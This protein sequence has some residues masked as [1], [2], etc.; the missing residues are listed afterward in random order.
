[1]PRSSL[2]VKR[3][4]S[5]SVQNNEVLNLFF[6]FIVVHSISKTCIS[7]ANKKWWLCL[8]PNWEAFAIWDSMT[9]IKCSKLGVEFPFPWNH[10]I[11]IHWRCLPVMYVNFWHL[12]VM[13]GSFFISLTRVLIHSLWQTVDI[14]TR[15]LASMTLIDWF[16][17]SKQLVYMR[18]VTVD[19]IRAK[20]CNIKFNFKVHFALSTF[21]CGIESTL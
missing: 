19:D 21:G 11:W 5:V 15:L 18:L 13:T 12:T 4:N 16:A 14:H 6:F 3:C 1:M 9:F 2:A 8:P 7:T 20:S 10:H 17:F